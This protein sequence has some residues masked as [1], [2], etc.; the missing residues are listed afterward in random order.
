MNKSLYLSFRCRTFSLVILL[1]YLVI[2]MTKYGRRYQ[3]WWIDRS[4][5]QEDWGNGSLLTQWILWL[6]YCNVNYNYIQ[7]TVDNMFNKDT[8]SK[9]IKSNNVV[10]IRC[11]F[12]RSTVRP[13]VPNLLVVWFP[14]RYHHLIKSLYA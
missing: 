13:H 5:L 8:I 3:R 14:I 11:R 12:H 9:V 2:C 4:A 7:Y 10:F 1:L 6:K